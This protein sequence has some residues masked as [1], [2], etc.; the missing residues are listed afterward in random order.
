MICALPPA[1]D[2]ITF[3]R[4][5]ERLD[6]VL[7]VPYESHQFYGSGTA[8][9]AAAI[10]ASISITQTPNP[11][12]IIPAYGCPS[13]ISAA[14]YA[15]AQPVLVDLHPGSPWTALDKV[16]STISDRTVAILAV[17]LFG[18][19]ERLNELRSLSS[20]HNVL[21]I[22]DGAQSFF[23]DLCSP[24]SDFL[25]MS[26]GRGKPVSLLGGGMVFARDKTLGG[27]LP[28]PES[29]ARSPAFYLKAAAYN[30][31]R[32]PGLYWIPQRLPGLA[33][34]ET[35]YSPLE[36]LTAMDVTRRHALPANIVA[37]KQRTWNNQQLLHEAIRPLHEKGV[38][39][40]ILA[41]CCREPFPRLSRYPILIPNRYSRDA[42]LGRLE[43]A[44]LGATAMYRS[45]LTAIPAIDLARRSF[46]AAEDF[47]ARLITLP[48][49]SSV[50][51]RHIS[52]ITAVLTD[53]LT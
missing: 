30:L 7:D 40:D 3:R 26:F 9:L 8:A 45:D 21:L 6:H 43:D 38:V 44:G 5:A 33:L 32:N 14:R 24:R 29:Q 41:S 25:V 36:S 34:G 52:A 23:D 12:V 10:K 19:P 53:C 47:A 15:R 18:I 4:T 35:R 22:E 27:H 17:N 31:L 51:R 13:L 11:E 42:L 49:H 39:L 46:P 20:D 50:S 2:P 28:A 1:G 48:T 37:A 16:E